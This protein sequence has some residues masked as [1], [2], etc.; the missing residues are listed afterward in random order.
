MIGDS[1]PFYELYVQKLVP[2][3]LKV[4]SYRYKNKAYLA[5]KAAIIRTTLP[6]F[7][8]NVEEADSGSEEDDNPEKYKDLQCFWD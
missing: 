5:R 1:D 6:F 4:P 2:K 3:D 7:V 8:D